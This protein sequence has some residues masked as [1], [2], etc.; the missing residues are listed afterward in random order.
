MQIQTIFAIQPRNTIRLTL[1]PLYFTEELP[2][3]TRVNFCE[4]LV[5]FSSLFDNPRIKVIALPEVTLLRT[6]AL[7]IDAWID[8]D[9]QGGLDGNSRIWSLPNPRRNTSKNFFEFRSGGDKGD[10]CLRFVS[11]QSP[12]FSRIHQE[13]E[14][15]MRRSRD[16][17]PLRNRLLPIHK[18]DNDARE[19][20]SVE[21]DS[22]SERDRC[23]EK[24]QA[25]N[26]LRADCCHH[27]GKAWADYPTSSHRKI[28]ESAI[29]G[30]QSVFLS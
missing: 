25:P 11:S 3:Y 15:K 27:A 1:E 12:L 4:L 10:T 13:V 9:R 22:L 8:L 16:K 14:T 7:A 5:Q 20:I 21:L 24:Q 30:T 19:T 6:R 29:R 2:A 23:F 18:R 28:R 17:S 26:I